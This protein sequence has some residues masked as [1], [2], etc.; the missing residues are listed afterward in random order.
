MNGDVVHASPL[1]HQCT[2]DGTYKPFDD[3]SHPEEHGNLIGW[4]QLRKQIPGE[5]Q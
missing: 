1:E 3:W 2:P 4:R 5:C